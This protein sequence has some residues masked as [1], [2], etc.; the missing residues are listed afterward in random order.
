MPIFEKQK[1]IKAYEHSVLQ[2][3]GVLSRNEEKYVI[4][5]FKCTVKTHSMMD[6]KH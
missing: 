5:N 1:V 4:N 6:E 3:L 2:L